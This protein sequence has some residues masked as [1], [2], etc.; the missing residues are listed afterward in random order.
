[1]LK[2]TQDNLLEALNR[3]DELASHGYHDDDTIT[4]KQLE[5]D[6]NLLADT[7][8]SKYLLK[9]DNPL[10]IPVSTAD[11]QYVLDILL[12]IAENHYPHYSGDNNIAEVLKFYKKHLG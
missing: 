1:M 4:A 11:L 10:D 12:D 5:K 8:D 2:H 7:L 3:I 6:Y 9:T